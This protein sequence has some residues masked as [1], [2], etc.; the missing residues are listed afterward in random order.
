M[1]GENNSKDFCEIMLSTI[2]WSLKAHRPENALNLCK[3]WLKMCQRD[4]LK[5]SLNPDQAQYF[6]GVCHFQLE[7]FVYAKF[8]FEHISLTSDIVDPINVKINLGSV[9]LLSHFTKVKCD[10]CT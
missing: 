10:T 9:D 7:D 5:E 3:S 8:H 1:V 6:L 2:K 4:S